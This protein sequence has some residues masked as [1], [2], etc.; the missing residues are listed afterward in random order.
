MQNEVLVRWYLQVGVFMYILH[1]VFQL[2]WMYIFDVLIFFYAIHP[3][4][5]N[6]IL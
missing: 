3:F 2:F 1:N 4:V 5:Q 6:V